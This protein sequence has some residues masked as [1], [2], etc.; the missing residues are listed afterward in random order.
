MASPY[1]ANYNKSLG[2]KN[3]VPNHV[4]QKIHDQQKQAL[5]PN[6]TNPGNP[7]FIDN[8]NVDQTLN[9]VQYQKQNS[10]I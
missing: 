8:N 10:S 1:I 9:F 2:S 4:I 3:V 6:T 5:R 7:I